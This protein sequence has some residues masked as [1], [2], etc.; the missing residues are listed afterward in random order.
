MLDV[1]KSVRMV[2]R[3]KIHFHQVKQLYQINRLFKRHPC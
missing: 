2:F 3:D 1:L